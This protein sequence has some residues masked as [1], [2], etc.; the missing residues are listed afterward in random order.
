MRSFLPI[1]ESPPKRRYA[2]TLVRKLAWTVLF[3][4]LGYWALIIISAQTGP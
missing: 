4:A 2:W 1:T 3:G